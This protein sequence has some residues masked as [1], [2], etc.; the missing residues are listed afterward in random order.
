MEAP[1]DEPDWKNI[2][3]GDTLPNGETYFCPDCDYGPYVETDDDDD[4]EED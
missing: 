2:Q 3:C 1:E 4:D